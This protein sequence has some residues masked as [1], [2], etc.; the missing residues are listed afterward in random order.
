MARLMKFVWPYRRMV[1]GAILSLVIFSNLGLVLPWAMKLVIDEVLVGGNISLL[2]VVVVCL[3][4]VYLVRQIFFFISHYMTYYSAQRILFDI[5][6]KLFVHLQ[7]MSL[8]FYESYRTGKL[9]SNVITDVN[10]LQQMVSTTLIHLAVHLFMVVFIMAMLLAICWPLALV[11]FVV[12][13]LHLIN[14]IYF[15]NQIKDRTLRRQEQMSQIS[16]NLAETLNGIRVVKSFAMER[17]EAASFVSNIRRVFDM[18]MDI[19][20]RSIWCHIIAE[21][22]VMTG[23]LAAIGLGGLFVYEG[24][25]SVGS[26]VA[27]FTYLGM[28]FGPIQQLSN[29]SPVIAQGLAGA[30]RIFDLLDAAPEIKECEDPVRLKRIEGH[31]R[32]RNVSFAYD[33]QQTI[34]DFNLH[35]RPGSTVALVGPSGSG[36]S[37]IANL[38]LRFY[39]V[40][41]GAVTVD[42]HDL[43]SLGLTSYRKQLAVVLQ[44]PFLFSG[45]IE[46]NIRYGHRE[47]TSEQIIQAADQANAH[48]FITGLEDGY[49][50]QVGENGTRLSGGQKQRIAIARALLRDPAILI[51]DEATSALDT[52]SERIVQEALDTL[53]EDRTT[54]VIAHRLS[55]IRSAD[56]VVVMEDGEI[57]QQGRHDALIR[58]DGLYKQLYE[59]HQTVEKKEE[60]VHISG[61]VRKAG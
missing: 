38:L 54:L 7:A 6:R 8:R 59:N 22:L 40:Q 41:E 37:T 19:H 30:A 31:I 17:T 4:I 51:L 26:F 2:A 14:F 50:T 60:T 44:E 46:E 24:R 61:M 55:T 52:E 29:L 42:G 12:V 25:M 11:C 57:R 58:Q 35:I 36:K 49:R 3:A 1:L 43:R 33:G 21:I 27:F 9:I 32:F 28:M 34:K 53:M 48:E 45:T 23:R 15:K 16:G 47:A 13:P 18:N 5:R 39:D 56:V 10:M 20:T